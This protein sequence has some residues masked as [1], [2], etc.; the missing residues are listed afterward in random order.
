VKTM[1]LV[2]MRVDPKGMSRWEVRQARIARRRRRLRKLLNILGSWPAQV[3][4]IVGLLVLTVGGLNL[5]WTW[6]WLR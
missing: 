1:R 2:Y 6:P 5:W 4:Y 3:I